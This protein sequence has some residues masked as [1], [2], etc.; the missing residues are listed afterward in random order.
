MG[1]AHKRDGGEHSS[2]LN[3][4]SWNI[5]GS[6]RGQLDVPVKATV[7]ISIIGSRKTISSQEAHTEKVR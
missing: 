7:R 4:F 2:R 3:G 5:V 1:V 6:K